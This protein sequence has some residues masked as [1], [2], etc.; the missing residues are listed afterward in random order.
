MQIKYTYSKTAVKAKSQ[1]FDKDLLKDIRGAVEN[2]PETM[3]ELKRVFQVAN[4]RIQNIEKAKG[5]IISPALISLNSLERGNNKFAVFNATGKNWFELRRLYAK[6]VTFLGEVTSTA[7]GARQYTKQVRQA[8]IKKDPI[9]KND[10]IWAQH[11]EEIA[12]RYSGVRG[13]IESSVP[14]IKLTKEMLYSE[15]LASSQR[16][17]KGSDDLT[18]RIE[19]NVN[20]FS[21]ETKD[22]IK[23]LIEDSTNGFTIKYK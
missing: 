19:R 20:T 14:Y 8:L 5:D 1:K 7:S 11:K 6:A 12:N 3:K 4:R 9:Y 22:E 21:T 17:E 18:K 16:I 13:K 23:K 15:V 10:E 2:H